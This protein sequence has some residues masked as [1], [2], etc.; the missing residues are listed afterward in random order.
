MRY[1]F[2]VNPP[3]RRGYSNERSQ[4]AG[5]GVSRKLKPWEKSFLFLPPPDMMLVAAIGEQ[6]G[7]QTDVIDL[8]L[9]RYHDD[10]A[11][12]YVVNRIKRQTGPEDEIWVGVRLS[13]PTLPPD[14]RFADRIKQRLP[15]VRLF[16][17][18]T[19]IMTTLDHWVRQTNADAILYG[20]PEAVVGAMFNAQGEDWKQQKGVIDPKTYVPLTGDALYDEARQQLRYK[21][22]VLVENLAE[23]PFP[24]YHL[25]PLERYSPTGNPADCF[26]YVTASRGCPIGCTMCPYMLHEGRPLRMST[27]DRVVAEMEWLNKT[28]GIHKWRF[29]DPN[30]GFNRQLVR[31]ILTKVIERGIKMSA[32]VEVSL[33][34][35]EDDLIELMARAGVKTIT[36]GIET[37]DEE[38]MESIGQKIAINNKLRQKIELA[39]SLGIHV[40]GTFVIGAPEESWD[41]VERTIRYAK[42]MK[43]E[44]TFTLMTPFPGT[45]MYFRAMQEGLLE[46]EMTYEK[47]DSYTA[48]VRSRFL[49]TDDLTLARWWARLELVIP[50]RLYR[51]S[52]AGWKQMLLA[53]IKL[54][55]RRI[56]LAYVRAAV[57]YRR[58]RGSPLAEIP[59]EFAGRKLEKIPLS[60]HKR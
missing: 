19:V 50:Y 12:D 40:F 60:L 59:T 46:K 23:L 43:C 7:L 36:T 14:L 20:E 39:D 51:A 27:A 2:L 3:E 37:A 53:Q 15:H 18:G 1:L 34:V 55:P 10:A 35:L 24:A 31:E 4:S 54:I 47:W 44:C 13:I 56:A 42:T 52:K 9:E 11:L 29:R 30:F 6:S 26:V 57:A 58:R 25:L 17:F 16:L 38:C 22:W 21:E 33:E 48:T 28:W 32:T 8:L 41:T 45:P 5:L 49:T